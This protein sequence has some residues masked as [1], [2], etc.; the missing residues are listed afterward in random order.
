VSDTTEARTVVRDR[1]PAF[2]AIPLSQAVERLVAF[3]AHFKRSPARANRV[4]PAWGMKEKSSQ[5]DSTLA[6]LRA[7]GLIDYQGGGEEREAVLSNDGRTYLRAQTDA[8]KE[9]ILRRAALRPRNI[10]KYWR[11]WGSDR[12]ADSVCIDALT[13]SDTF[14]DSGAATFL[15]VYDGTIAFARL[16]E[17]DKHVLSGTEPDNEDDPITDETRTTEL[18]PS[19]VNVTR[20]VGGIAL[21]DGERELTTGLLAK[22]ASFRL[23]VSGRIGEKE[24]ERLIRKLELDK[25]ILSD[26]VSGEDD[27]QRG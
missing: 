2:P 18:P 19:P 11:K 23:I 26:T 17:S 3:E 14:S 12:P 27:K 16:M 22:D 1:S 5:A 25:E 10:E 21:M 13:L 15:K 4:G 9:A 24:I 20:K 7:Y 8:I 6:A